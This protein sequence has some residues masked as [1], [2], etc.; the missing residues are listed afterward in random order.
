MQQVCEI[1]A[2]AILDDWSRSQK[3]LDRVTIFDDAHPWQIYLSCTDQI[4]RPKH[5]SCFVFERRI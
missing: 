1:G 4:F 3:R 2:E 5:L